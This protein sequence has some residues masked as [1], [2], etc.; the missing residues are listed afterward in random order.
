MHVDVSMTTEKNEL[1]ISSWWAKEPGFAIA[2]LQAQLEA[3]QVIWPELKS[4]ALAKKR[5]H[6]KKRKPE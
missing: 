2:S 4:Y 3:A 5:D 1:S 6:S